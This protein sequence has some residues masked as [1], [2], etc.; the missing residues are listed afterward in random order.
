MEDSH[1]SALSSSLC[2]C[3]LSPEESLASVLALHTAV[4]GVLG[5]RGRIQKCGGLSMSGQVGK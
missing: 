5:A 3:A 2:L 4:G 1:P